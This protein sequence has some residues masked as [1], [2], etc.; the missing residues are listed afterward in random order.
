MGAV[1]CLAYVVG[2]VTIY[3]A[4]VGDNIVILLKALFVCS[5]LQI[6]MVSIPVAHAIYFTYICKIKLMPSE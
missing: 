2:T 1:A 6:F 5:D 4:L 3:P